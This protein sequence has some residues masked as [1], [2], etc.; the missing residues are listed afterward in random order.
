MERRGYPVAQGYIDYP[1]TLFRK[2]RGNFTEVVS[3]PFELQLVENMD[4]PL[5][6]IYARKD[7]QLKI[8]NSIR[9]EVGVKYIYFRLD[10][11]FEKIK[12]SNAFQDV[13]LMRMIDIQDEYLDKIT[14]VGRRVHKS[15]LVESIRRGLGGRPRSV[16]VIYRNVWVLLSWDA[17]AFT[18]VPES[19]LPGGRE[20]YFVSLY[21]ELM[22]IGIVGVQGTF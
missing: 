22:E 18:P 19:H 16:V 21:R 7:L 12:S 14:V 3:E 15:P 5:L 11:N 8:L 1:L 4:P 6:I 20:E 10:A 17:R 2:D 9:D 13:K